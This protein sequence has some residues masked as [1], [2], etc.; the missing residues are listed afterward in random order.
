M[1]EIVF[2]VIV[3]NKEELY[4]QDII[5]I[6]DYLDGY[7]PKNKGISNEINQLPDYNNILKFLRTYI[8]DLADLE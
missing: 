8:R 7:F 2:R 1:K 3:E 5:N 4:K 6:Q